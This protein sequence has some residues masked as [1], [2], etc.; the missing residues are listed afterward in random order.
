MTTHRDPHHPHPNPLGFWEERYAE[1]GWAYGSEPNTFVREMADRIPP[2]RVL[3]LGEGQGRNAVFLAQRG[4]DVT[5]MDQSPMGLARASELAAERG[6][7]ITTIA[8]D[9][10]EFMIESQ[11][12]SGIVMTFVHLPQPLRR[13]VHQR[14][15]NGLAPGGAY[16]FEAYTPQQLQYQTGGPTDPAL[17]VS[18]EALREELFRLDFEVAH[19]DVRDVTEGRYHTGLASTVQLLARRRPD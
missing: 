2:G 5:A 3:C 7:R 9:L 12:F 19:E 11:A 1:P 8:A 10:A 16:V 18:L 15:M 14:V 17:L 4:F 6:V 13:D